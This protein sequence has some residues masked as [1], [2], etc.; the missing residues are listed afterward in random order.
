VSQQ[1]CEHRTLLRWPQFHLDTVEP[2]AKRTEHG[3]S[4]AASRGF[5][6]QLRSAAVGGSPAGEHVVTL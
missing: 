1:E 2:R 5:W 4:Q 3:Q 6:E